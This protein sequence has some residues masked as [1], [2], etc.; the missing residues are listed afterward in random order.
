M[1]YLLNH[2]LNAQ[3]STGWMRLEPEARNFIQ[4]LHVGGRN[5]SCTQCILRKL[6]QKQKQDLSQ[7]L[8][9]RLTPTLEF[10]FSLGC[11]HSPFLSHAALW[12]WNDAKLRLSKISP[13]EN[14]QEAHSTSIRG[15]PVGPGPTPRHSTRNR[16]GSSPRRP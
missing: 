8:R 14:T 2:S 13:L 7:A 11:P 1:F 6:D 10:F 12:S 9:Y 16:T 4:V 5:S 15:L 3:H